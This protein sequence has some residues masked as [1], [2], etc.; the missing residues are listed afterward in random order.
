M[1]KR[2]FVGILLAVIAAPAT[3]NTGCWAVGYKP[4][5]NVGNGMYPK[6]V[7]ISQH[8]SGS[9]RGVEAAFLKYVIRTY[10]YDVNN[11]PN[12]SYS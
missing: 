5:E 3:A 8:F 12:L 4:T 7:Y 1:S 6:Y 10:G 11:V 2:T 9:D